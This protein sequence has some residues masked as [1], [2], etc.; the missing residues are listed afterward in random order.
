MK[1]LTDNTPA[2]FTTPAINE[3]IEA[4]RRLFKHSQ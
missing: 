1:I 4:S 3:S 2:T